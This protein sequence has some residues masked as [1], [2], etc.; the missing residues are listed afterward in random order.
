MHRLFYRFWTSLYALWALRYIRRNRYYRF[1]GLQ[2]EVPPGVFHPGVFWSTP[3]FLD[4][5]QSFDFQ[6]KEV[7]DIGSGS[8]LISLFAAR[9]GASVTALD[10]NPLAVETTRRNA[11]ANGL[12][13]GVVESDLFD[14]LPPRTFDF[15]L[16]NPPYYQAVP[17]DM[18]AR[19]FFAGENLEYFEKLFRQL[20]ERIHATTR[21]WMI[22][23]GKCTLGKMEEIA[24]AN[25]LRLAT[26][27]EKRKW[28]DRLIVVAVEPAV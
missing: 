22:L 1:A 28:G 12:H 25:A 24:A 26:V 10:I 17:P 13:I 19:A 4:F 20:P 21:T 14:N 3:V 2:V 9:R 5:L 18:A 11:A 27:F 16:V 8:G 6:G 15:V 7:L 23:S